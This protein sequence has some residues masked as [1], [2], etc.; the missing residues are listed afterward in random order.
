M[1]S[2]D[3]VFPLGSLFFLY[4]HLL[5]CFPILSICRPSSL[6]F[7]RGPGPRP[8]ISFGSC[9]EAHG[10]ARYACQTSCRSNC[11]TGFS[12]VCRPAHG[13][14]SFDIDHFSYHLSLQLLSPALRRRSR[15]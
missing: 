10:C 9:C 8:D 5:L 6:C 7:E 3:T 2:S 11:A 1:N 4:L 13:R 12:G 15:A 14:I